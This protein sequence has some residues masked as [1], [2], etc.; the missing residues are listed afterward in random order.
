MASRQKTSTTQERV[1]GVLATPL[2]C[3]RCRTALMNYQRLKRIRAERNLISGSSAEL[4][5]SEEEED[6]K[7][8]AMPIVS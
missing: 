4:A 2:L 8:K 3:S 7:D 6:E 5:V 1:R